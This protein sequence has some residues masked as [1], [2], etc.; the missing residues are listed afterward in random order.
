MS[1]KIKD[2]NGTELIEAIATKTEI[3]N[4]TIKE[5]FN[6]M[7]E[8]IIQCAKEGDKAYIYKFISFEPKTIKGRT[9]TIKGVEWTS[10]DKKGLRVKVSKTVGKELN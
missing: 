7:R 4:D 5:V 6:A 8:V 3:D 2:K 1:I 10:E 9:G